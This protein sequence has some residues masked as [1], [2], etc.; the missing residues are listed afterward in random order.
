[1]SMAYEV[2]V[3]NFVN[4]KFVGSAKYIDSFD[5]SVGKPWAKIPDS[6]AS[7]VSQAVGAAK[8]AFDR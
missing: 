5:P 7:E 4:G 8:Q 1:M 6:N 2:T 3:Q